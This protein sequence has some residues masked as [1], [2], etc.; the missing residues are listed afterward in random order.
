MT[1]FR[2][3]HAADIH[4]DSP[5][6][7][8]ARHD[9]LPATRIREATRQA[10]DN[11]VDL[12]LREQVDFVVIAGDLYDG[13]WKDAGT[14]LYMARALGRLVQAGIR[15]FLLQGNHDAASHITHDLPLPD[16]VQRFGTRAPETFEIDHLR[17]ALH[18]QSFAQRRVEQDMTPRYPAPVPGWFNIGVLHTSLSGHGEHETYAPCTPDALLAKGYDYWALG[19]V[20]ERAVWGDGPHI[21]FPGVL[22]GRHIRESGAKG[23]T[24]V[25]VTEGRVTAMDHLPCD[26]VR[27]ARVAVDCTDLASESAVHDAIGLALRD[28]MDETLGDRLLVARLALSGATPLHARLAANSGALRIHAQQIAEMLPGAPA[29]EKIVLTTTLPVEGYPQPQLGDDLSRLLEEALADPLLL[30]E[31][32]ADLAPFLATLPAVSETDEGDAV[33]ARVRAKAWTPL[34]SAAADTLRTRFTTE[35]GDS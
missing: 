3:L 34:L 20:H 1:S 30:D 16:G 22:Q 32:E 17:V 10:L 12:A 19:H 15:V 7:G 6:R 25:S 35:A 2:F 31:I 33:L 24:L 8:L 29:I 5:L 11:L 18:G 9:G 26:V 14:G 4:L 13:T 23:A 21:V 28:A 27:W